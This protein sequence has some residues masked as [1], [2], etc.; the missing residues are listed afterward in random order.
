MQQ[1]KIVEDYLSSVIPEK[2]SDSTKAE[3]RAEIESHIYDKAEF[4]I[5]IGYDEETA[6]QKAVDEMGEAEPVREE[7]TRLYKDSTVKAFLLFAG[8]LV[9]N[10]IAL[11]KGFAYFTIDT[12]YTPSALY[13]LLSSLFAS[14]VLYILLEAQNKRLEKRLTAIFASTGLILLFAILTNAIFQPMFF[15]IGL[16]ITYVIE[17]LFGKRID[18]IAGVLAPVGAFLFL[19]LLVVLSFA[20]RQKAINLKAVTF[21]ITVFTI[22][23]TLGYCVSFDKYIYFARPEPDIVEIEKVQKLYDCYEAINNK[24]TLDEV[25]MLLQQN[26]MMSHDE[27]LIYI[28]ENDESNGSEYEDDYPYILENVEQAISENIGNKNGI[29]YYFN[30]F[31]I[32]P[33]SY[34]VISNDLSVKALISSYSTYEYRDLKDATDFKDWFSELKKGDNRSSLDKKIDELNCKTYEKTMQIGGKSVTEYELTVIG[35]EVIGTIERFFEDSYPYEQI[36][37]AIYLRFENDILTE[38]VMDYKNYG[39]ETDWTKETYT[40]SDSK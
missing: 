29:V 28:K 34:L 20:K 37:I 15:G 5:E 32:Y 9:C 13:V 3:L 12:G 19:I 18:S 21:V 23:N 38:G 35:Y 4:Y 27:Y 16:N 24:M 2:I 33:D 36:D 8:I 6:F 25:D 39:Y 22:V 26:G 10:F 40:L 11:V 30:D 14:A 7:F 17:E 31:E 1:R